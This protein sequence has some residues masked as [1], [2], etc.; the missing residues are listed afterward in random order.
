[1]ARTLT[2]A[3]LTTRI[4]YVADIVND[5]HTTD[6]E[7][8]SHINVFYPWYVDILV[9]CAPQDYFSTEV[10]IAFSGGTRDYTIAS[11][12]ADFYKLRALYVLEPDGRYRPLKPVPESERQAWVTVATSGTCKMLYIPYTPVL[13]SGSVD[14]YNG[15]EELIVQRVAAAIKVKREEDPS[16]FLREV[17]ELESRIRR[18]SA[19][20]VGEPER[21]VRRRYRMYNDL[22]WANTDI[23]GYR[24]RGG[25]LELYTY[26]GAFL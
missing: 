12:A 7:I 11:Y 1:M 16:A 3:D 18:N 22:A 14:G 21:I 23:D 6:A 15:W 5:N 24:I 20:D 10:S 9:E 2:V 25:T 26:K 19:K 17:Q 13:T 4:R 8:L